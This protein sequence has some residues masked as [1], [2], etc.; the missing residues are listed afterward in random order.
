MPRSSQTRLA[1]ASEKPDTCTGLPRLSFPQGA[2]QEAQVSGNNEGE[3]GRS[4]RR[5][6]YLP[7]EEAPY[8]PE[9]L[10]GLRDAHA[11]AVR[12]GSFDTH[13]PRV[14]DEAR[15][16]AKTLE[17]QEMWK[18]HRNVWWRINNAV[19]DG[20]VAELV[21][22]HPEDAN[23]LLYGAM[24]AGIVKPVYA[25]E[26]YEE[27]FA[28]LCRLGVDEWKVAL[29]AAK[30]EGS[31]LRKTRGRPEG[32]PVEDFAT[33]LGKFYIE[34]TGRPLSASDD[35]KSGEFK[36]P[37]IRF[38]R[39]ALAPFPPGPKL[40]LKPELGPGLKSAGLRSLIMRVKARLENSG[41]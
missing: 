19:R 17:F 6:L 7:P 25:R 1:L 29:T 24:L 5:P 38:M 31:I 40:G 36:G 28:Q 37:T 21:E 12:G 2:E 41:S 13:W 18:P 10:Q 3:E 9:Q 4:V 35:F 22:A 32:G 34:T 39:A 20:K 14:R 33:F 26:D 23:A 30:A 27:E 8:T 15:K 16:C 11:S